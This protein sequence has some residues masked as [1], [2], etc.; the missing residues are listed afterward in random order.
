MQQQ[1][2]MSK[3]LSDEELLLKIRT[4]DNPT[5][6]FEEIV[7]KYQSK[8]YWLI[9][10][11]VSCHEDASDIAQDVFLKA[12]KALPEFRGDSG[13]FTWLYRITTNETLSFINK[14]KK[15]KLL[16]VDEIA[17]VS[18]KSYQSETQLSEE[19]IETKIQ[20]AIAKLPEKQRI[21]FLLRYYDEMKYEEM[22]EL[23]KTSQGAL[24]TSYHHAA[25][26]IEKFI[27]S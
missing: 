19:L 16:S 21:V 18:Q 7:R 15:Q 25:K 9:R 14:K 12:W 6:H 2:G 23:L 24:K 27:T 10:R 3:K 1:I 26:K 22:A 17:A 5:I 20:N 11:M 13:L 4:G 8:V